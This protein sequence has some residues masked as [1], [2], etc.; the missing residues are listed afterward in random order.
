MTTEARKLEEQDP[1]F[2]ANELKMPRKTQTTMIKKEGPWGLPY[3]WGDNERCKELEFAIMT[4]AA[5]FLGCLV[6]GICSALVG[7][8]VAA[9][10]FLS[11][12]AVCFVYAASFTLMYGGI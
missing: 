2:S 3:R 7:S 9:V 5:L 11:V 1:P 8:W 6:G 10:V 12:S 4:L